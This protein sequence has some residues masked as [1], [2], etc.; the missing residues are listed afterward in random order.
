MYHSAFGSSAIAM[1]FSQKRSPPLESQ[2]KQVRSFRAN[3]KMCTT[4]S[5][6]RI[7]PAYLVFVATISCS[8]SFHLDSNLGSVSA[9]PLHISRQHWLYEK[10][11]NGTFWRQDPDEKYL[12]VGAALIRPATS[13]T[14]RISRQ[15]GGKISNAKRDIF[16]KMRMTQ[17][18][19]SL[20]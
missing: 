5:S 14:L 20:R 3:R 9:L 10:S 7:A 4:L 12:R 17:N 11:M 13:A 15:F 2:M 16:R 18:R 19:S 1:G 6:M 8:S